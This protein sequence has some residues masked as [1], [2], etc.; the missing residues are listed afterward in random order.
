MTYDGRYAMVWRGTWCGKIV[1]VYGE[2]DER[3]RVRCVGGAGGS[4]MLRIED[5][6]LIFNREHEE[7]DMATKK[8]TKKDKI[9]TNKLRV[10]LNFVLEFDRL[11]AIPTGLTRINDFVIGGLMA[12]ITKKDLDEQYGGINVLPGARVNLAMMR[13][14]E[15][16][17]VRR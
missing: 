14:G 8:T 4:R 1:M 6:K 16:T 2:P 10:N 13:G 12:C 7:A 11:P 15:A 5:L 3:D 17:R 9:Q